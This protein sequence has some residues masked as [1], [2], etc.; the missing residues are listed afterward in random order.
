MEI[1]NERKKIKEESEEVWKRDG[2]NEVASERKIEREKGRG[3]EWE[4]KEKFTLN[5]L[6]SEWNWIFSPEGY[7][8]AL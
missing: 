5:L 8:N 2:G 3:R 1:E 4:R 6:S 7:L